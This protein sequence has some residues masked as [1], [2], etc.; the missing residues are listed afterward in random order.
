MS[1]EIV[2]EFLQY[3]SGRIMTPIL[4]RRVF[5][6]SL[7]AN[8]IRRGTMPNEMGET[9][10]AI[11][12]ERS[13]PVDAEPAW[14]TMAI[15]DGAEGGLCLPPATKIPIASTT[16]SFSMA[17]RVLEGPDVCNIDIRPAVDLF[18]QLESIAGILGD[19]CRIEWDIR[20]RHEYFRLCQTK[21]V[22][23]DC[24]EPTEST[25]M[26]TT[27]PAGC[28]DQPLSMAVIQKYAED[29]LLD[30]AGADALI[31]GDGGSPIGIVITSVRTRRNII[32][33]NL[34]AREDIRFSNEANLLVR[35]F[36]ISYAWEGVT[37]MADPYNR[38]F[39]CANG[40]PTEVPAFI[41]TAATKGQKAV[42][43][44]AYKTAPYEESF[45]YDSNVFTQLMLAPPTAPHPQFVFKP[46]DYTGVVRLHNIQDRTCNPDGNVVFHRMHMAAASYPVEP[47]RGVAFLH[48]R[49][50]PE[51]CV[52]DCVAT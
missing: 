12:Y 23:D 37:F 9:L 43:R 46:V 39:T 45:W 26:A 52:T 44:P 40:T 7:W 8:L 50:A 33:Q 28:P 34:E 38:R 4:K 1:C 19:Y 17:R 29:L 51:G 32:R 27:Y 25:T 36:G 14:G 10:T 15:E 16:R 49:C 30:G 20:D 31:R 11:V 24:G 18:N 3:E 5:P 48:E 6:R 41:L 42:V 21:V 22:V 47:E 35:T 2:T 13:A